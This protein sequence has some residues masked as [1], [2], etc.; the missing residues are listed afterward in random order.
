[1][2][3]SIYESLATSPRNAI[4]RSSVRRMPSWSPELSRWGQST[5]NLF[6]AL[7]DLRRRTVSVPAQ[8]GLSFDLGTASGMLMRAIMAG[9]TEF[10]RR[11]VPGSDHVWTAGDS[12][13]R[14]ADSFTPPP[15]DHSR[16]CGG[17]CRE[18]GGHLTCRKPRKSDRDQG[19]PQ[20]WLGQSFVYD[21]T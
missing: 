1:V 3:A 16:R 18:T 21:V 13:L 6:G 12:I 17:L 7:D 15:T 2:G 19:R 10:E 14:Q 8:T 5:P 9:L 20:V 11:F 4:S